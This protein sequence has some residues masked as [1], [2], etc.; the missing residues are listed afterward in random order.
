MF[1]WRFYLGSNGKKWKK[2]SILS[3]SEIPACIHGNTNNRVQMKNKTKQKKKRKRKT[4]KFKAICFYKL[5][6]L[7]SY[8]EV[9][10]CQLGLY[11]N[12]LLFV[13]YNLLPLDLKKKKADGKCFAFFIQQSYHTISAVLKVCLQTKAFSD[14]CSQ[15]YFPN[16]EIRFVFLILILSW[17]YSGVFQRRHDMWWPYHSGGW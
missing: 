9:W 11:F 13:S 10:N 6:Y 1:L 8:K 12:I 17:T 3:S 15:N 2:W 7:S 14:S 4:F 5:V 16:N